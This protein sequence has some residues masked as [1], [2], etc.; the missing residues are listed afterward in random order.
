MTTTG[1]QFS[2]L[3]SNVSH[4]IGWGE[5]ILVPGPDAWG[6]LGGEM[7]QFNKPKKRVLVFSFSIQ[8]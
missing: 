3:T 8:F 4:C 7:N 1:A 2:Q 5:G 6:S